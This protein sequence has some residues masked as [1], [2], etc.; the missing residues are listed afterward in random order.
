[1][2]TPQTIVQK[3]CNTCK[4]K[5]RSFSLPKKKSI[6]DEV[7]FNTNNSAKSWKFK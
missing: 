5:H 4:E 1:M 3:L 2:E 6:R 7:V